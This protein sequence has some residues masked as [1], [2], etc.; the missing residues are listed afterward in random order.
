[1][2]T[3]VKT[4]VRFLS[5]LTQ[6]FLEWKMLQPRILETIKT[7]IFCAVTSFPKIVPFMRSCWE[8]L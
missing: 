6:F 4:Y 5:C 8:I 7:R 1:M 3:Y 2:G